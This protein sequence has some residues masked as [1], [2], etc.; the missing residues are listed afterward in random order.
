M[1]SSADLPPVS[2]PL[3][4]A[5]LS[6]L[7]KLENSN[8]M[9]QTPLLANVWMRIAY[10]KTKTYRSCFD[11]AGKYSCGDLGFSAAVTYS[12]SVRSLELW[13]IGS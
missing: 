12:V 4:L 11:A 2:A 3:F 5:Y 1:V 13:G 10:I 6:V 7:Q 9:S 8:Y